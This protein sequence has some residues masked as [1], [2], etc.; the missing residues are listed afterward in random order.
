M[1]VNHYIKFQV[2][3]TYVEIHKNLES[4]I[5]LNTHGESENPTNTL[6]KF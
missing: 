6:T 1:K 3:P 5:I 4:Q 2:Q